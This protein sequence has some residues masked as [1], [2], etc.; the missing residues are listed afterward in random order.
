MN[1]DLTGYIFRHNKSWYYIMGMPNGVGRLYYPVTKCTA[2]GKLFKGKTGFGVDYVM[3]LH[4]EGKT[5]FVGQTGAVSIAG[6]AD[7]IKKRRVQFL[8]REIAAYTAELNKL[9]TELGM[10]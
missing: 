10:M 8:E 1:L 7:G 4:K 3:S 2:T 6:E 9:K 5:K